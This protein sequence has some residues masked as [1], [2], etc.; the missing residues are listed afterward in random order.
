MD[1][2]LDTYSPP[3]LKQEKIDNLNRSIT[4]NEI[5]YLMKTLPAN[6]GAGP[7]GFTGELY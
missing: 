3:K 2:F 6:K 5:E 4:R 1:N 7:D